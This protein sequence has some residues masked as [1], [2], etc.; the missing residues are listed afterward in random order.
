LFKIATTKYGGTICPEKFGEGIVSIDVPKKLKM[1]N[2]SWLAV[3]GKQTHF[4]S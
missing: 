1:S 3:I 2:L 4:D